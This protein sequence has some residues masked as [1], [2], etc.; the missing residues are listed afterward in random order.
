MFYLKVGILMTLLSPLFATTTT[1][2]AFD[3]GSGDTKLTVAEVDLEKNQMTRIL[4]ETFESIPLREDLAESKDGLL[5]IKI[6]DQ[7]IHCL[8]EMQKKAKPFEPTAWNGIG[9]S[10]FRT[11]KNGKQCLDRVLEETGLSISLIPQLEEAEIGFLSAV[12]ASKLE[13]EE[14]IAWDSGSGS[15]QF[16]TWIDSTILMFGSEFG[17]VPA[18]EILF[19]SRKQPYSLNTSPNPIRQEEA[20]QLSL[21]I[22]EQLP[23]APEWIK[24]ESK[25]ICTI[26]GKTSIFSIA[27]IATH[28]NV[29]TKDQIFQAILDTCEKTDEE[30]IH[31]PDPRE[32]GV[33]LT[34][35]Y[36]VMKQYGIEKVF[37]HPTNGSCEGILLHPLYWNTLKNTFTHFTN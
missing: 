27:A 20:L 21:S 24:D 31:F 18:L 28:S 14:I 3:I 34:L 33:S 9:T 30:L 5:S 8:K 13:K 23:K 25:S 15:F 32:V 16:S 4:F 12:A 11:A 2:A 26:G 7:L 10:V 6:Q 1:R 22:Q 36:S 17:F 29:Y 19:F 35:I 37:Y